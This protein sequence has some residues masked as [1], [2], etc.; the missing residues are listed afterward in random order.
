MS[1]RKDQEEKE[2]SDT[3][4]RTK[5]GRIIERKGF[6]VEAERAKLFKIW[7][8]TNDRDMSEIVDELIKKFLVAHGVK[9]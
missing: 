8:V 6:W 9:N 5:D 3:L 4:R 2:Q 1:R 7:C